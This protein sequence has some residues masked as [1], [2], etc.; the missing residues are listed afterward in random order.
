MH[1]RPSRCWTW[2]TVSRGHLGPP[3]AA[4]EEHRQD[5]TITQ[6]LGGCGVWGVQQRLRLPDREPVAQ[7]D[8]LGRDPFT[9]VIPA[10]KL[11]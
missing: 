6:P 11:D 2:G 3:Q 10:A 4:A 5:R 9:R 7:A 1:Q 8:P